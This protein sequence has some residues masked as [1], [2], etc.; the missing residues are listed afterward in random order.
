MK[1]SG[2]DVVTREH[3]EI[4]FDSVISHI[5]PVLAPVAG[6]GDEDIFVAP[7]F[8]DLQVN[9]FAGAD[10]NSAATPHDEILRSIRTMFSTGVTRFFPTVITGPPSNMLGALRNLADARESSEDG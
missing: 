7:G 6:G 3:I 1:C 9:G 8:I 10:Y 2:H 4:E 5:D